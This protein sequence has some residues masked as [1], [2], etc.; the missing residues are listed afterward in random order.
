[1]AKAGLTL[2]NSRKSLARSICCKDVHSTLQELSHWVDIIACVWV[3]S[4]DHNVTYFLFDL[5]D[6]SLLVSPPGRTEAQLDGDGQLRQD[7]E[8]KYSP[9]VHESTRTCDSRNRNS[10]QCELS[11]VTLAKQHAKNGGRKQ[12][13]PFEAWHAVRPGTAS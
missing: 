3:E 10:M 1:M 9:C 13:N 8:H 4:G 5:C 12:R 2:E 11:E 6:G 7:V